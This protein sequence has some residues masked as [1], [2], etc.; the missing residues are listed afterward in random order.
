[1]NETILNLAFNA[2]FITGA[3]ITVFFLG[4]MIVDDNRKGARK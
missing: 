2:F 4:C 3:V 1:M